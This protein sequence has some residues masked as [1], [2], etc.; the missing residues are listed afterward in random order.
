MRQLPV[1]DVNINWLAWK[2]GRGKKE[3]EII[4]R[5]VGFFVAL[6]VSGFKVQP[7]FDGKIGHR[8]KRATY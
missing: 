8:S 1:V 3:S 7:I 5:V 6:A 4:K 2:I